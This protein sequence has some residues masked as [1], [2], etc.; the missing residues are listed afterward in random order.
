MVTTALA[1]PSQPAARL[2][3]V[4]ADDLQTSEVALFSPSAKVGVVVKTLKPIK[5][6]NANRTASVF[7]NSFFIDFLSK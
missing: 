7:R 3:S 6:E 5:P 4:A 1:L 2:T